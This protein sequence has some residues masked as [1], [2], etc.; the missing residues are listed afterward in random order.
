MVVLGSIDLGTRNLGVGVFKFELERLDGY[1]GPS[2]VEATPSTHPSEF[3]LFI[4]DVKYTIQIL[5]WDRIDIFE[6]LDM[7]KPKKGEKKKKPQPK[8]E[9]KVDYAM[10]KLPD[11]MDTME[12]HRAECV[13]IETQLTNGAFGNKQMSSGNITMK[14]L[15]H[16]IQSLIIQRRVRSSDP[17]NTEIAFVGGASTIPLCE[18]I[19]HQPHTLW[20]H[21]VEMRGIPRTKPEKK[22]LAIKTV[23]AIMNACNPDEKTWFTRHKKK[24][25]LSDSLL[26]A[27]AYARKHYISKKNNTQKRK[28][29]D[30][31]DVVTKVKPAYEKPE[32]NAGTGTSNSR[33]NN[34]LT[35]AQ[36]KA[37]LK[38]WGVKG[39]ST[40]NKAALQELYLNSKVKEGKPTPP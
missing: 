12:K 40:L 36:L 2:F 6:G 27:M 20:P 19:Q 38:E 15:S 17:W 9:T 7:S 13:V 5:Y 18:D 37:Q 33:T 8:I 28:R 4:G 16:V 29:K 11:L 3:Q 31:E 35:V 22:K 23:Q 24:D 39:Y 10:K 30:T 26:Q 34:T 21:E 1:K 32:A 25:D 14:V